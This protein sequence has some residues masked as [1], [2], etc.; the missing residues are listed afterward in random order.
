M[1]V[2]VTGYDG[3]I[4]GYLMRNVPG[5]V[6]Q[7]DEP[8][9]AVLH[10]AAN[11]DTLDADEY[12]MMDANVYR[13][14]RLFNKLLSGGCHTF[15]FA[16]ST[17]VYGNGPAPYR[18]SQPLDPLNA[19]ARSKVAF[20]DWALEWGKRKGVRVVGLRYCNVYGPGECHK[21][22]R[23]STIS[24]LIKSVL[25]GERPTLFKDGTQRRDWVHVSDVGEA[26]RL[27]LQGGDG[28][29]NVGSGVA[30]T[31]NEVIDLVWKATELTRRPTNFIDIP[32]DPSRYQSH[33]ECGLW[34]ARGGLGYEPRVTLSEGIRSY[35]DYLR[36]RSG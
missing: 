12:R 25:A 8:V 1:R 26:N 35:V 3:F 21:G 10:Q 32:F 16:S 5:A 22:R 33:T 24:H 27:A 20:E 2:L 34:K 19:Y 30:T 9:E 6:S 15:V 11:N 14:M 18:E 31:F 7:A 4:G 23:A 13:P 28:V 17:A 29:Y 36:R